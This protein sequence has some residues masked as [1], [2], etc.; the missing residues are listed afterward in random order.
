GD[1]MRARRRDDPRQ[2][3]LDAGAPGTGAGSGRA[4]VGFGDRPYDREPEPRAA[5]Q[6]VARGIRAVKA[7]EHAVALGGRDSGPVVDHREADAVGADAFY[8]EP[9]QAVG[10]GGVLD[11]I[12]R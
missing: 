7:L 4:V 10:L 2:V 1:W 12:A 11:C 3:D 5:G 9:H 8:L 6:A